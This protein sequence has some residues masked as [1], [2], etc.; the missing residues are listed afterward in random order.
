MIPWAEIEE[1]LPSLDLVAEME[2][3]FSLYSEGR[4]ELGPEDITIADLTGV[5]VQDLMIA[6][7]VLARVARPMKGGA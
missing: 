5:A 7:A 1:V 6:E 3:G 2:R 4:F